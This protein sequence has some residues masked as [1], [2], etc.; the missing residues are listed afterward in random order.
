MAPDGIASDQSGESLFRLCAFGLSWFL[1]GFI[2]SVAAVLAFVLGGGSPNANAII[3]LAPLLTYLIIWFIWYLLPLKK[4]GQTVGMKWFGLVMVRA[5]GSPLSWTRVLFREV[6][7]LGVLSLTLG[8]AAVVWAMF[9]PSDRTLF[10]SA[11]GTRVLQCKARIRSIDEFR[12]FRTGG[13]RT[14]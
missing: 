3:A 4:H 5:D 14:A 2:A 13:E 1:A 10:D 8:L 12:E 6:V 9:G 11:F 7:Q